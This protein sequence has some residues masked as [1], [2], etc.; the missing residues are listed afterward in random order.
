[1]T[2]RAGELIAA[3]GGVN[4]LAREIGVDKAVV[5]R[6]PSSG[7]RGKH[8]RVPPEY[9]AAILEAAQRRRVDVTPYLDA[10]VCPCCQQPLEPGQTAH[11]V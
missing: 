3:F 2:T 11:R 9:N 5:S 10:N 4:A 1:M 7:R 8:G 6:W